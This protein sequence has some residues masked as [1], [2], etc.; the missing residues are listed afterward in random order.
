M[1]IFLGEDKIGWWKFSFFLF[2]WWVLWRWVYLTFL[3]QK[4]TQFLTCI[5]I[6]FQFLNYKSFGKKDKQDSAK[7]IMPLMGFKLGAII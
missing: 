6:L 2:G 3:F 4:L 5:D 1:F 7:A